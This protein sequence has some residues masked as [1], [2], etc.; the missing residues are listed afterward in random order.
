MA[1]RMPHTA[2]VKNPFFDSWFP[3]A[4][5]DESVFACII[6]SSL[7]HRRTL[8]LLSEQPIE[9]LGVEENSLLGYS[10]GDAVRTL[11]EKMR[12]PATAVTD[13]TILAVFLMIEKPIPPFAKDWKKES[14]FQAPLRGMQWLNVHG[15]REPN[16]TH[17]EGLCKL[18]KLR[19]GLYNV[20]M[21]G[22]AAAIS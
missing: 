5:A 1:P 18:I 22:L 16:F 21:P 14:P 4:L 7:T 9:S 8:C 10:Y 20:R 2:E 3:L 15:A 12:S 13:A 11:N 6:L 17:Q 19:G